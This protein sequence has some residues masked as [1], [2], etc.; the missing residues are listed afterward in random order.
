MPVGTVLLASLRV[1]A[2]RKKTDTEVARCLVALT[3][4]CT[5]GTLVRVP[6]VPTLRETTGHVSRTPSVS[7]LSPPILAVLAVQKVAV[8]RP[9]TAR[10]SV[11]QVE[12][13]IGTKIPCGRRLCRRSTGCI[14]NAKSQ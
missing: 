5:A 11:T 14:R 2:V 12:T 6:L 1:L 9:I 10:F 7:A 8:G 13:V 3:T 4:E